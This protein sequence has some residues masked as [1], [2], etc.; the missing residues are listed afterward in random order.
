MGFNSFSRLLP[1]EKLRNQLSRTVGS[2]VV[3]PPI[4]IDFAVSALKILQL[5]VGETTKLVAAACLP[6]PEHLIRD[7]FGRLE[8]QLQNLAKLVKQGGFKGKRAVCTIPAWQTAVK[9]LAVKPSDGASLDAVVE[10]AIP[11]QLGV[12]PNTVVYRY[13][14]AGLDS[15]GM[16]QLIL[17]GTARDQVDRLIKGLKDAKLEPVG[18]QTEYTALVRAFDFITRRE[19]DVQLTTLYLDVG[20]ASTKVVIA[21]GR[22]IAFARLI[23]IGGQKLDDLAAGQLGCSVEQARA[24]RQSQPK[25]SGVAEADPTAAERV[26]RRTQAAPGIGLSDNI[27]QRPNESYGP[28]RTDLSEPVEILTDEVMMC[29]RYFLAQFPGRK[30]D[31]VIFVGGESSCRG[32]C[33]K[34]AKAVRVPAQCADPLAWAQKTGKEPSLGMDPKLPQPGWAVAVG[35]SLS[36]TDL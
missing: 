30:L 12:M 35:L 5:E 13:F 3:A 18:M 17:L 1:L 7:N 6:T 31:R 9:C 22:E 19:G 11:A 10:A 16:T 36:P 15:Q 28:E 33:Q 23:E 21:K 34:I 2:Q 27:L 25:Q 29:L 4:A 24:I 14:E 8:F 26:D 32:I 20:S